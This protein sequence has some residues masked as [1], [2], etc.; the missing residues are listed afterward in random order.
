MCASLYVQHEEAVENNWL[1]YMMWVL[2]MMT[3]F[4]RLMWTL[5][6]Q[7]K[8]NNIDFQRFCIIYLWPRWH[9]RKGSVL[10]TTSCYTATTG[11]AART[12][13]CAE[14]L[15]DLSVS[16]TFCDITK[17]IVSELFSLSENAESTWGVTF[18]KT[19]QR[20]LFWVFSIES[21]RNK[22]KPKSNLFF[23]LL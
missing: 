22:F 3:S 13:V 8:Y 7:S 19:G 21:K 18:K 10:F 4:F 9:S 6:L 20:C 1:C 12:S 5:G 16:V 11:F 15:L 23:R 2:N 17:E 14:L